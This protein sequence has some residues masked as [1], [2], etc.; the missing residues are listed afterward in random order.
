MGNLFSLSKIATS[1]W[2]DFW[3]FVLLLSSL[4]LYVGIKGEDAE[5]CKWKRHR[6]SFARMVAYGVLFE[7]LADGGIFFCSRHLQILSDA[8]VQSAITSAGDAETSATG[9]ADAARLANASAARASTDAGKAQARA[10]E[11]QDSARDV[12]EQAKRLAEKLASL[13]QSTFPRY[14]RQQQFAK[15]LKPFM[16]FP[17]SVETITDFEAERTAVII[18]SGL[19]MAHW[20]VNWPVDA[21]TDP[22]TMKDFF[23]PGVWVTQ[24]CE[25]DPTLDHSRTSIEEHEK[26]EKSEKELLGCYKSFDALVK[27]LNGNGISAHP[28]APDP[29]MPRN[30][31]RVRVGLKPM[32]GEPGEISILNK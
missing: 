16:G 7:F 1:G 11:A 2:L 29:L 12:A 4:V 23:S 24:G 14:L 27:E 30:T 31:L 32:P 28:T 5:S 8:E 6:P 18:A 22:D 15:N 17:V 13:E 10:R 9:A 3:E 25:P 19:S 26:D 21:R 20:P